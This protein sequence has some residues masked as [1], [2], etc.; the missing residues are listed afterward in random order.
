[1]NLR[2]RLRNW[3]NPN[4]LT[5]VHLAPLARRHGFS[6]G[7]HSYGRPKVRFAGSGG[8]LTVGRYCSIGDGVEILLGGEHR[9]DWV[10]TFP[11]GAF[12]DRWPM[13]G[14]SPTDHQPTRGDVFIGSDVWIGTGALIR[15]GV[16]VGHGAAIGARAVVTRDVP[17][18]GVVAGNPARL[19]RT[20]F[21][22]PEVA[23]LLETAWWELSDEAVRTL[24]PLLSGPRIWDLIEAVR[25]ARG[26]SARGASG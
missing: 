16:S 18:Y 26:T 11:F 12:P 13:A 5:A 2:S 23:A 19:I 14:G 1:M 15:S 3:R 7:A 9:L 25:S 17:P 20:R 10:S 21:P 6:V 24:A 8:C 4:N 22:E